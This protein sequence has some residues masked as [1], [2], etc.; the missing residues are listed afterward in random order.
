M[1]KII[2]KLATSCHVGENPR[3]VK[4]ERS[5]VQC[6]SCTPRHTRD[7]TLPDFMTIMAQGQDGTW[8]TEMQGL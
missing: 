7:Q 4:F 8:L 1:Y 3:F 5:E 6:T 2:S